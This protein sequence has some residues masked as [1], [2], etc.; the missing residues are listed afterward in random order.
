VVIEAMLAGLPVVATRV[1]GIPELVEDGVTGLLVP[2]QDPR[3]LH[4]ALAQL[5]SNPE[6][7]ERLGVS[8]QRRALERFTVKRMIAQVRALY[9]A[10]E[11]F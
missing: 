5:L 4:R 3:A 8:G 11:S 1:G 10:L 7:C 9:H 2:P 6:L